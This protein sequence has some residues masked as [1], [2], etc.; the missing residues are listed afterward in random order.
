[1]H[2]CSDELFAILAML[3]FIGVFFRRI[4]DWYHLKFGHKCHKKDCNDS[5]VIHK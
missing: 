4:H 3:P 2:F 5:H 1:M